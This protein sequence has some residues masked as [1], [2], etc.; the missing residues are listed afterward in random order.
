MQASLILLKKFLLLFFLFPWLLAGAQNPAGERGAIVVSQTKADSLSGDTYAIITGVSTYTGLK[1]LKYADADALLFRDFLLSPA[2]GNTKPDNIKL[3]INENAKAAD[4]N[5][6][7]LKWLRSKNL[8][9]GD[10]LYIYFSGHGDAMEEGL[11]FLLPFDCMPNKDDH[12]YLGTGNIDMNHVKTLFIKPQTTKGVEVFLIVDACRTNEAMPGGQQGQQTFINNFIAEQKMG[13]IMLL[14]TG[15]GQVSIEDVSIGNGHGLFTYYLIDGLAGAADKDDRDGD[16]N[17][18][19]NLFEIGSYVKS[20]VKKEAKEKFKTDQIPFYCCSEKDLITVANVNAESFANWENAKKIKKIGDDENLFAMNTPRGGQRSVDI[21]ALDSNQ[22]KIYNKFNEAYKQA[23][24]T[25]DGSADFFYRQLEKS[26]P[27]TTITEDAKFTLATG[28]VN[29]CQ[30]KINLFLSGKGIVHILELEKKAAQNGADQSKNSFTSAD[31]DVMHKLKTLVSTDYI[32]AAQMMEKAIDML[33]AEP[34]FLLP[35]LPKYDFLKTMAA[36]AETKKDLKKILQQCEAYITADPVSPAGFLL[37]AWILKDMENDSSKYYFKKAAAIAPKWSYPLVGLGNY[38]SSET[39]YDSALHYFNAALQLDSLN[40]EAYRNRGLVHFIKGGYAGKNGMSLVD[41]KQLELARK[42][43]VTA[44]KINPKDCYAYVYFAD[45][46]LA[47]LRSYPKDGGSYKAYYNNAL[48]N[49]Q[50]AVE[51]DSNFAL[52]YQKLADF[53]EFTGDSASS[54]IYLNECVTKNPKNSDG[55]RNLG[56]YYLQTKADTATALEHLKKALTLDPSNSSNYFSLARV[57][58]KQ[59][60]R[61]LAI[62]VYTAA[63][64]QTGY[65]K[66]LLNEMGNTYFEPPSEFSTAIMYYKWALEV[67]S[68]LS[69]TCFNLGKLYA[70]DETK[71][72]SSFYYYG[73]AVTFDSYRF[74][75]MIHPVADY[76]YYAKR[77]SEAKPFYQLAFNFDTQTKYRDL[78]RLVDIF[79]YEKDFAG[80]EAA[81]K[82]YLNPQVD[83]EQYLKLTETISK[84]AGNK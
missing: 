56:N 51:C 25:G 74:R 14:S 55:F 12:N 83:N 41:A 66:D 32:D 45:H 84:A 28:F 75:N 2:G 21:T 39:N 77:F 31:K 52:G 43:F 57:Y 11:Y 54:L 27:G 62:S 18:N 48:T 37:K 79:I 81:V 17:G 61:E 64:K 26:W 42:D 10:R 22:I 4:F 68:S 6:G 20:R 80:A 59:K 78:E 82:K 34:E 44:K 38:Y 29:F 71:K 65:T 53:F 9:K 76:Y 50:Q 8:K 47:F 63:L 46:Q 40:S 36:Y 69:Y 35:Y 49:Y 67:D 13:D 30:Q 16:N 23:N 72:D 7:A 58:R 19:V 5:L 1:P 15:P 70:I 73:R 60:K 3:L 33:K 24:L